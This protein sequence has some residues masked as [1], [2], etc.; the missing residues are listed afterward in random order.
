[1]N[2]QIDTILIPT[3]TTS[4]MQSTQSKIVQARAAAKIARARLAADA[5]RPGYHFTP[6]A[7]WMNDPNG[8]IH[9]KGRYHLFYQYNPAAPVWGDIHW[10]HAVSD[11]LVHWDD[12]PIAFAPTPDSQDEGGCWSGCAFDNGGV[13][14]ILYTGA[15]HFHGNQLPCLATT[16]DDDLIAWT[17]HPG[18]PVIAAPPPELDQLGFRDHTVWRE[19]DLW[20]QGIGSG[21]RDVGGT[22]LVYTSPD[23]VDWTYV[24][25]LLTGDVKDRGALW[26][27]SLWE[28][29][30]FFRLGD[31]HVL[32]FS[33][34]DN[35]VGYYS[36][37]MIGSYRDYRF[38]PETAPERIDFGDTYFY[39]P[40]M[41][42]DASGRTLMWG[43]V[44]EGRGV[45]SQKAAGWSGAMS[46][47]RVLSL[48]DDGALGMQPAP[49]LQK[50]RGEAIPVNLAEIA[51]DQLYI[52]EDI[53]GDQLEIIAAFEITPDSEIDLHVRRSPD[54]AEY[55]RIFY[56]G[57]TGQIGIDSTRVASDDSDVRHEIK[58]GMFRPE[59]SRLH[60]H[61]FI[62]HSVIEVFINERAAIT[63]RVYPQRTDCRGVA[64][65]M[66]ATTLIKMQAYVLAGIYSV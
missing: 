66:N 7:N 45:D 26:L 37:Y 38:Y 15:R 19:G 31:K 13:P 3:M 61:I 24:G 34:W 25:P 10:G 60:L 48:H 62:D 52:F 51:P 9:W 11:D 39:A 4:H 29:P 56:D 50:L 17:K 35:G 5:H 40:Q 33:A 32:V 41:M 16:S 30:Q 27:G 63:S 23:L 58:A 57:R 14:T 36:V 49:E 43:W 6:P 59:G 22:V 18:N 1:M 64:L 8:L 21:V 2:A 20:V 53:T 65:E 46:L 28:C 42:V 47:P 54:G 55:A 44:Q 12:L